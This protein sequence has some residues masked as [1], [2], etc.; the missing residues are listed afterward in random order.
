MLSGTLGHCGTPR[1]SSGAHPELVKGLRANPEDWKYGAIIQPGGLISLMDEMFLKT[2]GLMT[3][4]NV[5]ELG[6][7]MTGEIR[8]DFQYSTRTRVTKN[9]VVGVNERKDLEVLVVAGSGRICQAE[10]IRSGDRKNERHVEARTKL[11]KYRP[12]ARLLIF[13]QNRHLPS[14]LKMHW[15]GFT[16]PPVRMELD[17]RTRRG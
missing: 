14:A 7:M 10:R 16:R 6:E 3:R 17:P 8:P 2:S 15:L 4:A 13:L 11:D 1:P 9:S 12:S 5:H